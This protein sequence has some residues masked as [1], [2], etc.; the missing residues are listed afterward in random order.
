MKASV[1]ANI[2]KQLVK[3]VQEHNA[4]RHTHAREFLGDRAYEQAL[5]SALLI[6]LDLLDET[7]EPAVIVELLRSCRR[8]IIELMYPD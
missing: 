5:N 7:T 1:P 3:D 4:P 8:L 2:V 6:R